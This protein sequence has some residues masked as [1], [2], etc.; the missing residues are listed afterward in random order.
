V[1]RIENAR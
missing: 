1:V